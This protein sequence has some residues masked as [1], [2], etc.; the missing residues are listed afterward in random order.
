MSIDLSQFIPTFLEES[1]EGL[2][3]ME[4]S[5]L[6]LEQGDADTINAIFRA[7]H[8]IKGGAGTFGFNRVTD[9]T[10][11]VET[12]LDEMRDGRRNIE[13]ADVDLLLRS[14]DCIR[15]LVEAARDGVECTDQSIEEVH[16]GLAQTLNKAI[17]S[18]EA[19]EIAEDS[20][21]TGAQTPIWKISFIP[22]HEMLQT[23]NDVLHIINALAELGPVTQVVE[24]QNIPPLESLHPE[25]CY[26]SWQ[27]TLESNCDKEEIDEVFE[28]VEDECDLIIE[29]SVNQLDEIVSDIE[30]MVDD[31]PQAQSTQEEQ[32][33]VQEKAQ[34][35]PTKQT[36]SAA[37]VAAVK[38]KASSPDGGSIRVGID[39][40]DA[41][42]NRVGELVITQ[43]M[44]KQVG[45]DLSQNSNELVEKLL[46]GLVQLEGNTRDLQEDVM[47]IRMLPIS[48]VF[49]RFPR[50]VY[51]ISSKLGKKIE[52]KLSGEQTEL[53]KTVME[54]IGDPLVHLV[55]NS[56]DHGLELPEER[57]AA[58]KDETGTVH[59]HAYH[60]GGY[61][62]IDIMD[63]GRGLNTA[64]I[65]DKAL[66]K[67]LI[68]PDQNL[69][70]Q[71]INELI[72]APGF[73]TAE[74]VSDLS[75]RGVGMDVVRRNI[76][77]LGGHVALTSTPGEG[78][79]FSVSLPLTLAI[80]DGQLI[81]VASETYIV[82]LVSIIESAQINHNNVK[83]VAGN[84]SLYLFR[85]EYI[86]IYSIRQLFGLPRSETPLDESMVIIV[87]SNGHK[88]ALLVD[89]LLD[90][91][92]VVLKSLDSNYMAVEGISG[93]TILGDGGVALIVDIKGLN[94]L[95]QQMSCDMSHPL[96]RNIESVA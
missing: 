66:E 9:F 48:F 35:A 33:T 67:G 45:N 40:V 89:D 62:V 87:E 84:P 79:T 39:K 53:D 6:N 68:T 14:V 61:I 2:E 8:S 47:R 29:Q 88:Y 22:H 65:K 18:E 71:E 17:S 80:L 41:L 92:Q 73:S 74:Q 31:E 13:Q 59:L 46:E 10:H 64:R 83:A 7:A 49:N 85:D 36:A 70:D 90:Q 95:K 23:G 56:L 77:S 15:L 38:N 19:P 43:A 54:K 75:G 3:L 26:L 11:D 94:V 24:C 55:R 96:E 30:N 50:M 27:I 5:L 21:D 78:S 86:P 63:D 57:L 42:I 76:E 25:E 60:Q 16:K 28:W 34:P 52:L 51:D 69:S 81:R 32:S 12:L 4:S 1:F 72:F 20:P 91:Q 93:A 44:L 37:S 82:P 58:D